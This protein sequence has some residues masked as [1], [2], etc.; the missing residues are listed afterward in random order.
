M[1]NLIPPAGHRAVRKEYLV[2]V[3]A[4]YCFLFAAVFILLTISLIPTYVLVQAQMRAFDAEASVEAEGGDIK[5]VEEDMVRT[6]AILTELRKTPTTPQMS[7]IIREIERAATPGISFR[8]FSLQYAAEGLDPILVQ[9]TAARREE[10]V[11]LKQAIE[12]H[13]LFESAEVPLADL[14]KERDVPFTI[15]ITLAE[16][17]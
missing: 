15:T 8:N 6:E 9:G 1:I 10:L 11:A 13:E 12:A 17:Q 2:R 7:A 4:T 16:S 3:S 14:A 5:I